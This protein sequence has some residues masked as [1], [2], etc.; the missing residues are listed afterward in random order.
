MRQGVDRRAHKCRRKRRFSKANAIREA[1]RARDTREVELEPYRC[2]VCGC[3]H[4][5]TRREERVR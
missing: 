2:A 4:L 1:N 5:T 3:V